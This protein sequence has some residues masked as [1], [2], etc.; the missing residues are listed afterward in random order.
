MQWP[1]ELGAALTIDGF[2]R[3]LLTPVTGPA[4]M[5][6][7]DQVS[8]R[9]HPGTRAI[10]SI[11]PP[12]RLPQLE[13]LVGSRSGGG[14]RSVLTDLV[15]EEKERDSAL[16]LLLDDLAGAS[17]VAP[18]VLTR[19][20]TDEQWRDRFGPRV[21]PAGVCLGWREG[22]TSHQLDEPADRTLVTGEVVDPA[23]PLGWHD[24]P[25]VDVP[26]TRRMRRIDVTV[27]EQVRVDAWFQDSAS[28]P[29]GGRVAV[30]EYRVHATADRTSGA[31]LTLDAVPA[32]LPFPECPLAVGN[33]DRVIG[34]PLPELRDLVPRV[35]RGADGCTHLNDAVRALA[36]VPVLVAALD[37]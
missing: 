10:E 15:P 28:E 7:G 23:D 24:L 6:D 35:L 14:L 30:H 21:L 29:G 20:F 19:F 26:S 36:D 17:L 27:D 22:A 16:Y 8:L 12:G 2:A 5:L 25:Q 1:G 4:R 37:S 31:L 33:L 11:E 9:V 18:F 34:T 13:R 32:A 3:D